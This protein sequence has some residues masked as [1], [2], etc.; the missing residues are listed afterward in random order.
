MGGD[1]THVKGP[2]PNACRM[3]FA[4]VCGQDNLGPQGQIQNQFKY[5]ERL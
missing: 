3:S 4:L 5:I 1:K 2:D